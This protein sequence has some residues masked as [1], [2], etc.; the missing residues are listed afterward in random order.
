MKALEARAVASTLPSGASTVDHAARKTA[1]LHCGADA[2]P[3]EPPAR[4][5]ARRPMARVIE[6]DVLAH[7]FSRE[8][9]LLDRILDLVELIGVEHDREPG[10]SHGAGRIAGL[11]DA[12]ESRRHSRDRPARA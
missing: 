6:V 9:A 8:E 12:G 1:A 11:G 7:A 4:T 5:H 3:V 10:A 2:G